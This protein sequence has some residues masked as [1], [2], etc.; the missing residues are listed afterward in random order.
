MVREPEHRRAVVA[1]AFR[2]LKPGGDFVVHV[3]HR[4]FHR[5]GWRRFLTGDLRMPQAYGGALLT[6]HHFTKREIVAL[7]TDAGFAI[8]EVQALTLNETPATLPWRVYG[9]L[10]EAAK[11]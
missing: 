11:P 6:I 7:L 5:L 8:R 2:L 9:F 10:I 4:G 1:N 3:H